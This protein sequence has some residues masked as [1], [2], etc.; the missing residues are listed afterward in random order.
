MIWVWRGLRA[1]FGLA[2]LVL[3]IWL[4]AIFARDLDAVLR[5]EGADWAVWLHYSRVTAVYLTPLAGFL[6]AL[7]PRLWPLIVA[8]P[9]WVVATNL[10]LSPGEFLA[11]VGL[12]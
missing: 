8:L 1:V 4:T 12:G 9:V 7:W 3:G 6:A 11:L 10:V 2:M 5:Y